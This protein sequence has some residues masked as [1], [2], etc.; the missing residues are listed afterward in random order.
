MLG[1]LANC[2]LLYLVGR[3][4]RTYGA[5]GSIR[6]ELDLIRGAGLEPRAAYNAHLTTMK[7]EFGKILCQPDAFVIL[8]VCHFSASS[9]KS[10]LRFCEIVSSANAECA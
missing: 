9:F 2:V 4:Q 10:S 7:P 8:D 5:A 1:L 3:E 6:F